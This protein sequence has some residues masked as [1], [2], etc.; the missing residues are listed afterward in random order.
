[1]AL[2][3]AATRNKAPPKAGT[4]LLHSSPNTVATAAVPK[5]HLRVTVRLRR[6][7]GPP[8]DLLPL[9]STA[10]RDT[11][12]QDMEAQ[13]MEPLLPRVLRM[14]SSR[15]DNSLRMDS[16]LRTDN[17]LRMDNNLHMGSSLHTDSSLHTG[18]SLPTRIPRL[19][20]SILV[21]DADTKY[22]GFA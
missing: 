19:G 22:I 6:D 2:L 20:T 17:S 1:M 7:N 16:S 9:N 11:E 5:A 4:T 12:D 18:N 21:R 15:M 13:N 10:D 3:T 8:R 14:G